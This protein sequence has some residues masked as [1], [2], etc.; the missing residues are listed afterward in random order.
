[1]WN[2]F[3]RKDYEISLFN[4]IYL[5]KKWIKPQDTKDRFKEIFKLIYEEEYKQ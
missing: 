2:Y 3:Y 4:L 1:M 5:I